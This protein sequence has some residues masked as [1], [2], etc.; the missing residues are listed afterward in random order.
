M[1]PGHVRHR[2]LYRCHTQLPP[3]F[4]EIHSGLCQTYQPIAIAARRILLAA[5]LLPRNYANF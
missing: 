3:W 2:I 5:I 4:Q 1:E